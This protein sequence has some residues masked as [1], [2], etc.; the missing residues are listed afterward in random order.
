[1]QKMTKQLTIILTIISITVTAQSTDCRCFNGIGS[2][3]FD[4]PSLTIDFSNGTTLSV[5][6]Y[7]QEKLNENEV[8]ISE[9]NVFNCKNR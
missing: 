5:C 3:E 8:Y 1:M 2:S 4:E 9:F 7:E 6:G